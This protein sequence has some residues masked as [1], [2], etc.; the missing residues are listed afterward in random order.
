MIRWPPFT[1]EIIRMV[2]HLFLLL[3]FVVGMELAP[4]AVA[5]VQPAAVRLAVTLEPVSWHG[6][7]LYLRVSGRV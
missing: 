6:M 3:D 1:I 2:N 5:V 7:R 4:V